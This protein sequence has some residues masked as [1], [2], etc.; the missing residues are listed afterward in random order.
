VVAAPELMLLGLQV[1]EETGMAATRLTVV[2]WEVPF[3]EAV[4]LALWFAVRTPAVAL[5]VT[6]LAPGGTVID[7]GIVS[8]A[9]LCVSVTVAPPIAAWFKR[10]V[11]VVDAPEA[12]V[13]GLQFSD[14]RLSD[15]TAVIVPPVVVIWMAAAAAEALSALVTPMVAPE[16]AGDSFTVRTAAT[17]F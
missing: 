2:V 5:K 17:P 9:L 12:S 8:G 6:E 14:V 16:I 1:R 11:Q 15:P 10:T 4:T 3:N 13:P 7:A